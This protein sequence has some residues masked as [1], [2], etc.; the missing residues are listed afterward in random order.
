[1]YE[2]PKTVPRRRGI[3][4]TSAHS[5]GD[6]HSSRGAQLAGHLA[7]LLAATES[8]RAATSD[9]GQ[10][11]GLDAALDQLLT[12]LAELMSTEV[13]RPVAARTGALTPAE[14]HQ[15]ALALAGRVLVVAAAQQDTA[16]AMLACRRMDAHTA[17]LKLLA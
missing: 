6:H 12:R 4:H 1:M 7:A 17:A 8:V 3:A 5:G 2:Q 11:A 13:R 15:R 10:R 9:P 14:L 16:T